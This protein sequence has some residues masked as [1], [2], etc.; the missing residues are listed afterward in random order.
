MH[1]DSAKNADTSNNNNMDYNKLILAAIANLDLQEVL[2]YRA[3]VKKY[4]LVRITIWLKHTSQTVSSSE[5]TTEFWQA[6]NE[7]QEKVLLAILGG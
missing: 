6:L 7:V 1:S 3:T 5:A 4:D 2:N